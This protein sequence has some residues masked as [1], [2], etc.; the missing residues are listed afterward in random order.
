MMEVPSVGAYVMRL[1][2]LF[3][4]LCGGTALAQPG[5]D[6]PPAP[7]PYP[8]NAPTPA[9]AP[10]AP[11]PDQYPPSMPYENAPMPPPHP[12]YAEPSAPR[13]PIAGGTRTTFVSTTETR[14]DVRIDQNAV[15]T[16]PCS[17]YVEP[18]RF[19]T[20]HTQ[21]RHPQKVSVGYL[22]PGDFVVNAKP[23][24]EG[25]FATGITFTTLSGAAVITG[26]TLTAVGC[27]TDNG[28]MCKAGVI[29]GVAGGLGLITFIP[30]IKRSLPKA[31]VGPATGQP[32]VNGQTAGIAGTF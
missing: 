13:E 19:I 28:A 17:L 26:I 5:P 2:C 3:L 15:C 6:A 21:H 9:P 14:W 4:V 12:G 10:P 32:Y 31:M 11:Q 30:M 7:Q 24:S 27:N 16:T 29:T 20:M 25:A 8:Y 1:A 18:G 22:P 23:R